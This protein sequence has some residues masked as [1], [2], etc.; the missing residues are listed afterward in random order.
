VDRLK[1]VIR[2]VLKDRL[3]IRRGETVV[4]LA[5][6]RFSKLANHFYEETKLFSRNHFLLIIPEI[7]R[8]CCEPPKAVTSFMTKT[9]ILIMLTSRSLSHTNARSRTSQRGTRIVTLACI[10]EETILRTFTVD[11][12]YLAAKSRK[13]ADILTIGRSAHL[14]TPAGTD[15]TFSLL[16]MRGYADT[17]TVHEPGQFTN[18]PAGEACITPVHGTAEGI[19]VIDGS[20]PEIGKINTP[21]RMSVKKGRVIR[22]TGGDETV[23]VRALLRGFGKSGKKITE[24]GVGTNPGAKLTGCILEDTKV[25]GMVHV[26]L[27]NDVSFG[28]KVSAGCHLDGVLLNSTLVIDTKTVVENGILQV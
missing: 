6:T 28:G 13:I 4:I 22:I 27:G 21:I 8:Y 10:T 12:K 19:L 5:D 9:D 17:G 18:L 1:H 20:F 7:T 15:L 2:S 24:V 11:Y 25:L 16:R 3:K 26:G 14:T 23:Q